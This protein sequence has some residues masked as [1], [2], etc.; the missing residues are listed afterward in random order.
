MRACPFVPCTRMWRFRLPDWE[1][2][3]LKECIEIEAN[4]QRFWHSNLPQQAQLTLVGFFA[5]VYSQ[6]LGKRG[7]VA[8]GF[9]TGPTAIGSLSGVSAHVGCDA[10]TLRKTPIAYRTPE[11]FLTRVSANVSGQ[12]GSLTEAFVTI[13]T[14]VRAFPGVCSKVR[15]ERAWSGVRF[16]TEPTEVRLVVSVLTVAA[17]S[18]FLLEVDSQ[19]LFRFHLQLKIGLFVFRRS[20]WWR[21]VCRVR[22]IVRFLVVRLHAGIL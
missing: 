5:A 21:V 10:R 12:I 19:R 3:E 13:R 18:V 6:M 11:R 8:E 22:L 4:W 15:F 1:N 17:A 14:P 20:L 16:A 2:L 9:L 7:A